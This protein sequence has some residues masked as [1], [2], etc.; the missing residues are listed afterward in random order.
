MPTLSRSAPENSEKIRT[1]CGADS[2]F[3]N[4]GMMRCSGKWGPYAG[5]DTAQVASMEPRCCA[6]APYL[7]KSTS[8]RRAMSM[9]ARQYHRTV[10]L[11]VLP[12]LVTVVAVTAV[13][14]GD[15]TVGVANQGRSIPCPEG[16]FLPIL[17]W[18]CTP[19]SFP[20]EPLLNPSRHPAEPRV[21]RMLPAGTPQARC[22]PTTTSAPG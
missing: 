14:H 8:K 15:R 21:A 6:C 9:P 16:C 22:H 5:F 7:R 13:S 3:G 11:P 20:R 1:D 10:F 18:L 12:L 4:D 17:L 19:S 2:G